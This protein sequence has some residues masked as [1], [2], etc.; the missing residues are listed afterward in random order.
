MEKYKQILIG[1]E[2]R[3]KVIV[4]NSICLR[5]LNLG[6]KIEI[7]TA[8]QPRAALLAAGRNDL[9]LAQVGASAVKSLRKNRLC[10]QREA[11]GLTLGRASFIKFKLHNYFCFI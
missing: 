6:F 10:A 9:A 5:G 8:D 3:K 1:Q 4:P 7:R 2:V 11:G